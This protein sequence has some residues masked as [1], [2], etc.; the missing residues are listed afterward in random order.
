MVAKPYI[1]AGTLGVA[2][3]F[4]T[5][6][7]GFA[8]SI[9]SCSVTCAN[10]SSKDLN[11]CPP[12]QGDGEAYFGCIVKAQDAEKMCDSRC[13]NKSSSNKTSAGTFTGADSGESQSPSAIPN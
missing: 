7:I 1:I 2:A 5:C 9:G 3:L 12:L 10:H 13:P 4:G 8:N 6:D 11:N